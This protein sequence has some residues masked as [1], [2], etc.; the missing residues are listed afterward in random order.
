MEQIDKIVIFGKASN[1]KPGKFYK[2]KDLEQLLDKIGMP[3][4]ETVGVHL[5][6]QTLLY[7]YPVLFYPVIEEGTSKKCYDDGMKKLV[8][9]KMANEIIAIVMP[10]FGSRPVLDQALDLCAEKKCV[11]ILNEEDFYDFLS[12]EEEDDQYLEHDDSAD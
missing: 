4:D 11:L 8:K 10:G 12:Y 9:S 1:A 3:I 7:K 5:A 6:V 2:I